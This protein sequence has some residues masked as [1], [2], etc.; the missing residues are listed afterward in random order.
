MTSEPQG[1]GI[2]TC[3]LIANWFGDGNWPTEDQAVD[4]FGEGG[5]IWCSVMGTRFKKDDDWFW[6]M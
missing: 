2:E 6:L 1:L 5:E 4:T 3:G